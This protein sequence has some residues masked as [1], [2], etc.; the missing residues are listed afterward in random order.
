ML[1]E[2]NHTTDTHTDTL[3]HGGMCGWMVGERM[4]KNK[5]NYFNSQSAI[6]R[7]RT[8]ERK[9]SRQEI[10]KRRRK[11]K[12]QNCLGRNTKILDPKQVAFGNKNSWGLKTCVVFKEQRNITR[13]EHSHHEEKKGT[14]EI[15][16]EEEINQDVN[17]NQK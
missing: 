15:T 3:K 14:K 11:N 9:T 7:E 6:M 16:R 17:N 2:H 12:K 10:D 4:Y 8:K 5:S 1:L 13:I